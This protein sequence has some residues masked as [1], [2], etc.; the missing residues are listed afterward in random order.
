MIGMLAVIVAIYGSA[1]ATAILLQTRNVLRK[2][3]TDVSL[4]WLTTGVIGFTLY[5]TYGLAI[6]NLTLIVSDAIGVTCGVTNLVVSVMYHDKRKGI[7]R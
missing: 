5:F 3:K 1:G 6:G 7:T 4:S 2:R